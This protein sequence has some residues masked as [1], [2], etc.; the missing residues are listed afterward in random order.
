MLISVDLKAVCITGTGAL[1]LVASGA[2]CAAAK[3]TGRMVQTNVDA[4]A[5][6][7]GIYEA[8]VT[9][10][11]DGRLERQPKSLCVLCAVCQ[12]RLFGHTVL[13]SLHGAACRMTRRNVMRIWALIWMGS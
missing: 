6:K 2:A 7:L 12:A 10:C 9:M 8:A 5:R 1:Q 11:E 3:C 13:Q 4:E